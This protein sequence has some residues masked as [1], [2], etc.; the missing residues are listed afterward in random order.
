MEILNQIDISH[1]FQEPLVFT[2]I[3]DW[4]LSWWF[5]SEQRP[6][7]DDREK[8]GNSHK[9]SILCGHSMDEDFF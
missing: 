4:L 3:P 2:E 5:S 6:L 1:F 7:K 8:T 9:K